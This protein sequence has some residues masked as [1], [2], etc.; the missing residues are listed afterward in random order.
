[1]LHTQI[2][3]EVLYSAA[4]VIGEYPKLKLNT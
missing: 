4:I 2:E 3:E 1:M